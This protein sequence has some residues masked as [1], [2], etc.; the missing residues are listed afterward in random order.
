MG[1]CKCFHIFIFII[2]VTLIIICLVWLYKIK[3]NAKDEPSNRIKYIKEDDSSIEEYSEGDFCFKYYTT[4]LTDGAYKDF[5]I[6]MTNIRKYST[7]LFILSL[8]SLCLLFI[9]MVI[10]FITEKC[11][12]SHKKCFKYFLISSI[13]INIYIDILCLVLFIILSVHYYKS[14]FGDFRDFSRCHYLNRDFKKDY[15]CTFVVKNNFTK[16]FKLFI[17]N[18]ILLGIEN[19]YFY[20][21]KKEYYK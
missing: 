1:D 2:N 14:N 10:I 21:L 19:Y 5:D 16:F 7:Y 11:Y 6:K 12:S 15:D 9:F 3:D 20:K 18:F 13:T 4:Y 17:I 8:I